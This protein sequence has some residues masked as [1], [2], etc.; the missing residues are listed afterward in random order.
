MLTCVASSL[1]KIVQSEGRNGDGDGLGA[2]TDNG[3]SCHYGTVAELAVAKMAPKRQQQQR[4]R[5]R[6]T[7]TVA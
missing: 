7:T 6:T 4:E 2:S 3:F 5:N 1:V